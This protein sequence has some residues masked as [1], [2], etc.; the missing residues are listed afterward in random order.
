MILEIFTFI[1]WVLTIVGTGWYLKEVLETLYLIRNGLME[2]NGKVDE[3]LQK[4]MNEN[5]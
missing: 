5:E 2:L 3:E 4:E 1:L